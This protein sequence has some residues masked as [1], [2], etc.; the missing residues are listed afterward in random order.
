MKKKKAA[1]VKPR[2]TAKRPPNAPSISAAKS[3]SRTVKATV[4][5]GAQHPAPRAL[6]SD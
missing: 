6:S 5:P 4:A 3:T 1:P 2:A